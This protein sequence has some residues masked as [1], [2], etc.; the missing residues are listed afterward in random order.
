VQTQLVREQEI[1]D[2][3]AEGQNKAAEWVGC[4][5]PVPLNRLNLKK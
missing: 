4:I 2:N 1:F 5:F 3:A